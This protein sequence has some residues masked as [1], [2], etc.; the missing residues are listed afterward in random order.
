MSHAPQQPPGAAPGAGL[1]RRDPL[2]GLRAFLRRTAAAVLR[3][4]PVPR[5]VAFIMDGNRR[6]AQ[7]HGLERAT[8][9][10]LGFDTVRPAHSLDQRCPGLPL[11]LAVAVSRLRA[12]ASASGG[13]CARRQR[14]KACQV[15]SSSDAPRL[16][17]TS[18]WTAWSGA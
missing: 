14:S 17:F 10:A 9:H 18:W 8:G 11:L 5:H 12:R 3:A 1:S 15:V 16:P 13:A 2:R 6:F 4:G 7:A